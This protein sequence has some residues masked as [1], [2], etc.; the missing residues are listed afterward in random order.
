MARKGVKKMK[1]ITTQEKENALMAF[2]AS[3]LGLIT[4]AIFNNLI[5]TA[6]FGIIGGLLG[7]L[8]LVIINNHRQK[9]RR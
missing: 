4:Y 8:I 6:I 1:M 5:I 2:F 9:K 3:G 7:K